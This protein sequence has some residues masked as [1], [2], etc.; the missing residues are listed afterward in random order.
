MHPKLYEQLRIIAQEKTDGNFS[1]LI[2]NAIRTYCDVNNINLDKI[3]I[4]PSVLEAYQKKQ[5]RKR[6]KIK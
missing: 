6:R 1:A 2:E 3:K 4:D 5:D